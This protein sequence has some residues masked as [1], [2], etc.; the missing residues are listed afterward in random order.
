MRDEAENGRCS[1]E[2]KASKRTMLSEEEAERGRCSVKEKLE[3]GNQVKERLKR[4]RCS[5]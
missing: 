3:E 2:G 5:V 4:E 1:R